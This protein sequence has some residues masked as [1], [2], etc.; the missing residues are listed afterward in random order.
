MKDESILRQL[1]MASV[2]LV[3]A[4][5]EPARPSM[6]CDPNF[7]DEILTQV[8]AEPPPA[9]EV[10]TSVVN[11]SSRIA[12]T[13]TTRSFILQ[14]PE[15]LKPLILFCTHALRMRD[16]RS[17]SPIAKVLRSLITEFAG[18]GAIDIDVREYMSTEVLKACITSLHDPY[19]VELQKD[20]AQLIASILTDYTPRTE[21]P[22]RILLTLPGLPAEKVD[23][24]IRHLLKAKQ[25]I[26]QQRAIVLDLLEGFRGVAI[27]EQGKL[28]KPDPKK[29]RSAMQEQ[30]M[31]VEVQANG[32]KEKSPDLSGIAGMFG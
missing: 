24:S 30:Y 17:C 1:T 19:F 10:P 3:V 7:C 11:N 25:N 32:P 28:P 22:R 29:L 8:V 16:T 23:R 12:T 21:T 20:F 26:R 14:T 6:L 2:M 13:D 18:D 9:P 4:L 27:H 5:L 31:T 15:I